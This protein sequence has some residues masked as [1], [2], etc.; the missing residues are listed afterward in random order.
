[1]VEVTH[2]PIDRL[3]RTDVFKPG[4]AGG[5][6]LIGRDDNGISVIE[7]GIG[8]ELCSVAVQLR[9]FEMQAQVRV[10]VEGKVKYGGIPVDEYGGSV[11]TEDLDLRLVGVTR[12]DFIDNTGKECAVVYDIAVFIAVKFIFGADEQAVEIVHFVREQEI[13]RIFVSGAAVVQDVESVP[14]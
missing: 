13:C 1:M 12:L 11:R 2:E 3:A 14:G 6:V 5:D 8:G 4:E 9:V 10:D 7:P